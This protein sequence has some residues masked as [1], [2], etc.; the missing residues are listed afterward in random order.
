MSQRFAF[1]RDTRAQHL[2]GGCLPVG[3][4]ALAVPAHD[5]D[6]EGDCSEFTTRRNSALSDSHFA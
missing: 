6:H 5:R 1:L 2:C 4:R 3:E